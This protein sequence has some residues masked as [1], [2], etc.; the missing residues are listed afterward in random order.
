MSEIQPQQSSDIKYLLV[1]AGLGLGIGAIGFVAV[2][3]LLKKKTNPNETKAY[4]APSL[5][6]MTIDRN[7]IT[8]SDNDAKTIASNLYMAMDKVGTDDDVVISEL[9]KVKTKDDLLLVINKFGLRK[10]FAY[11]YD[12]IG[13]KINLIGW[14]KKEFTSSKDK[15]NINALISPF[16]FV[17]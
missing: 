6:M 5:S 4:Q 10:Y 11:G 17:I 12:L 13:R 2:K 3:R 1:K 8:I 9:T 7:K 14:L 16:G 15:E